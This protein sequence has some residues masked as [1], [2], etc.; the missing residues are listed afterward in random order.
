METVAGLPGDFGV[1]HA[2]RLGIEPFAELGANS[3]SLSGFRVDSPCSSRAILKSAPV[4]LLQSQE[5]IDLIKFMY[6]DLP[7]VTRVGSYF[8]WTEFSSRMK[9]LGKEPEQVL[10]DFKQQAPPEMGARS[11]TWSVGE[12]CSPARSSN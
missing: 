12:R 5:I 11:R 4:T 8:D 7:P 1:V 3:E 2:I 9:Q 6:P 10:E